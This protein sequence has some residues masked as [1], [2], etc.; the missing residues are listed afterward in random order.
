MELTFSPTGLLYKEKKIHNLKLNKLEIILE[1]SLLQQ[2]KPAE[3]S[4]F[5]PEY[6]WSKSNEPEDHLNEIAAT[7][8]INVNKI[9]RSD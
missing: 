6:G 9:K 5:K 4:F 8:N 7:I 2:N 3:M 1:D